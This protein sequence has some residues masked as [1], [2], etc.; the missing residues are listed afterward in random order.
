MSLLTQVSNKIQY[1]IS[2][3]ASDPEAEAYAKEQARQQQ[4]DAETQ[5]RIDKTKSKS[6][7]NINANEEASAKAKELAERSEF[8]PQRATS[9][10]AAGIIKG[11]MQFIFTLIV[12]YGGHLAANEAIGY[13]IPFRLLSFVY[14]CIFFFI[15]IPK[16]LIRRYAYQIKPAYYTYLPL[17]TYQP[18]GDLE[19]LFL[20]GFCYKEDTA[21]QLARAT[22]ETLYK[23]AFE[24]SQIKTE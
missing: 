16:M 18:N 9:N 22:V 1:S 11:F 2:Q 13:K 21:S 3:W 7:D 23:T 6:D 14:G 15:E 17:S 12:L 4:Q 8:K 5:E 20:G 10:I 24:K 19:V